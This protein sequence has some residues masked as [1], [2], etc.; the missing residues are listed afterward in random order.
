MTDQAHLFKPGPRDGGL[1][2]RQSLVLELLRD[3]PEGLRAIDV[4]S[5]LHQSRDCPH[6]SPTRTCEYA[7]ASG[8]EVLTALRKRGLTVHRRTGRWEALDGVRHLPDGSY[9]P[10]T[11]D[12][13]F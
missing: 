3:N 2:D 1:S 13:P 9:D 8:T 5:L 4:G 6:C 10:S 7:S 12:I 11:S